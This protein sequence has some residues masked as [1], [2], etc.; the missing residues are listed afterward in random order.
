[1]NLDPEKLMVLFAIAL[2]VLGPERMP[3]AA[4]SLGRGLA[5]LKKY[6]SMLHS[7]VGNLLEEPR[8]VISS[9]LQEA[10]LHVNPTQGVSLATRQEPLSTDATSPT[11]T[12]ATAAQAPLTQGD[13]PAP[14][15][16]ALN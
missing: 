1:M 3:Q 11:T 4:R 13:L 9:V 2:L 5:E 14:E 10:E 6:R 8:S 12:Y 15:D 16:P 7:E